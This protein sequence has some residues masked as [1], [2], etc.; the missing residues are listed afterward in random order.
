MIN[1]QSANMKA[2][3]AMGLSI[4]ALSFSGFFVR[5]ADAPGPITSLFRMAFTAFFLTFF[6]LKKHSLRSYS[7]K[8]MIFPLLAGIFSALDHNFW[9]SALFH[10]TVANAILFNYIA[11]VWVALIAFFLYKEK[12]TRK[13][14]LGMALTM[15]GAVTIFGSDLIQHPQI[16]WGDTLAI[17][18]SVFYAGFF[19]LSEKGRLLNQVVEYLWLVT[20]SATLTL[21][22]LAL[23]NG[24]PLSGYNTKTIF[25]FIGA[26]LFAQMIGYLALSYASGHL[27]ASTISPTMI[28]QPVLTAILA[29]PISGEPITIQLI[30]AAPLVLLGIYF[31]NHQTSSTILSDR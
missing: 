22:I 13:F 10:T 26:A 31:I 25:V 18:S 24:T 7:M 28:L 29:V 19:L 2:N 23:I 11:P 5:W 16:G 17:I 4:T 15:I 27:P 14:W 1:N 9:S 6:V 30:I 20:L 3:L 21:T 8:K 12:L